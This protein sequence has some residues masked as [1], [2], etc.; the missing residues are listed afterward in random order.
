MKPEL[1]DNKK[2]ISKKEIER[3]YK[4]EIA[5]NHTIEAELKEKNKR[6]AE[7]NALLNLDEKDAVILEG[8]DFSEKNE[9]EKLYKKKEPC[10]AVR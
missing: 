1:K 4:E 6:L 2:L 9:L 8:D 7:L 3:Q 10:E 5:K